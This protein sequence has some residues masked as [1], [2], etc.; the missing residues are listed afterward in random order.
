MYKF[1]LGILSTLLMFQGFSQSTSFKTSTVDT[2]YG[3]P[4]FD[5][6]RTL[7]DTGNAKVKKWMKE[8]SD[9]TAAIFASIPGRK[10]LFDQMTEAFKNSKTE[11]INQ[12]KYW[13]EKFYVT[14]R[15]PQDDYFMLYEIDLKGTSKL[16][17]DPVSGHPGIKSKNIHLNGVEFSP[18]S[19]TM[20]Y[21]LT[22]G[23]YETDPKIVM[24]NMITGKETSDTAY[25][26]TGRAI[27][28]FDPENPNAFYYEVL[29]FF[30]KPGVDPTRWFDSSTIHHHIIG[31]DSS[32]DKVVI[33][34]NPAKLKRKL[35]EYVFIKMEKN[36]PYV[37]AMVKN[38]VSD[39]YRISF[40][41]KEEFKGPQTTWKQISDF[42][43]KISE[44]TMKDH[45]L[46]LLTTKNAPN[47]KLLRMDL[48]NPVLA[49]SVELIPNSKKLLR[50]I[51]ATKNELLVTALDAGEGKLFSI[52]HGTVK[53]NELRLPLPGNVN[54]IWNDR[55][56]A[57]FIIAITSWISPKEYYDFD[58]VTRKFNPSVI[59]AYH[60]VSKAPLEVKIVKVK[61]HDGVEVPMTIIFKKGLKLDGTH[62]INLRGYGAYGFNDDPFFWPE[63]F[64][65]FNMG[66]IRAIA[67]VRGGGVNGE[68]WYLAGK[69]NT[70][71]NT[72]KDFIACAEYLIKNKADSFPF[73]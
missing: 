16:L 47:S 52:P 45:Y 2:F 18:N 73:L 68:E 71:P 7:E 24:R 49:N 12:V 43:D 50:S 19:P 6:Y 65:W 13:K 56:E 34:Y 23:G 17:I 46:Y 25:M 22:I 27:I 53:I 3:N 35:D 61:S 54:M 1:S 5:P 21:G 41:S 29:P 26:K 33:D 9:K 28:S 39:E 70:K 60:D 30:K 37:F 4:V 44:Y 8:Q 55:D 64:I 42:D 14:K 36:L 62:P 10:V 59:Q 32:T 67:H 63:D 57:N 31:S 66:G 58:P 48:R 51:D 72:W 69:K 40:V 20:L 15:L 38:Q 11:E